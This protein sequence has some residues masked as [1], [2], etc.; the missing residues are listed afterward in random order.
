M[1]KSEVFIGHHCPKCD[2]SVGVYSSV[3]GEGRCPKCGGQLQ[4][5]P[6]GPKMRTITN[7]CCDS[8]GAKVGMLSVVG[9]EARC[10][11]CRKLIVV[12][13]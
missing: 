2:T 10:P 11:G 5:A 13:D 4:A 3:G 8:C 1:S 9:G 6:G 7:F 12:A